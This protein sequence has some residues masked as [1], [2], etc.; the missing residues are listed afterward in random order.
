MQRV[1]LV[2]YT[3]KPE[4]T[5]ENEAL[6][7]AVFAQLRSAP[8][9]G[10]TYALFRDG[11][12]FIHV[13]LNLKADESAPV[14]ELPAFKTFEKGIVERCEASPKVT[15]LAVQLVDSYGFSAVPASRH[16]GRGLRPLTETCMRGESPRGGGVP[17]ERR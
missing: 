2:R 13:L 10:V 11:N 17:S 9:E 15:R 5:A 8:P 6:S 7:R 4:H 1:T 14:T 12:E 16:C 3:T